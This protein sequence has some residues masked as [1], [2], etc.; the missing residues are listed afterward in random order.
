[1]KLR[2]VEFLALVL[3]TLVMGVFWGTWFTLTRSIHSFSATEFIHI[4]QNDH[5]K[6]GRTNEY[7]YANHL[8]SNVSS[9]VDKE[10]YW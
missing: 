1:M 5:C 10:N 3:S 7:N 9:R 2:I 4:G 8:I 6:C